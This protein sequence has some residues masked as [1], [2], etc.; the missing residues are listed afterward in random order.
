RRAAAVNLA[1][2]ASATLV[3]PRRPA[4]AFDTGPANA[5]IDAA[6]RAGTGG[7][8]QFDADGRLAARG[9]VDQQLLQL[10][11]E[12]EYYRRPA[13]K[14]TGKELFHPDYL[15]RFLAGRS[16]SL[17]DVVATLSTR[18]RL[19]VAAA[20]GETEEVVLSG[21]VTCNPALDAALRGELPGRPVRTSDELG[22]PS[23]AKEA[24][25][26]AVLGFLTVN[27]QAG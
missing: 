5:Q 1:G 18:A 17:E 24:L 19:H 16:P 3:D 11:L 23:G 21:G 4:L 6:V 7:A 2:I 10:L 20:V 9:A 12:E 8:E 26:F 15:D 14:S 22:L 25:A 27:G 13:P